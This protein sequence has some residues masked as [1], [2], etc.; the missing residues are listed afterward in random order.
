MS[1]VMCDFPNQ[2]VLAEFE[3]M[4]LSALLKYPVVSLMQNSPVLTK[5]CDGIRYNTLLNETFS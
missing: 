2:L 5:A 1:D 4:L 3:N